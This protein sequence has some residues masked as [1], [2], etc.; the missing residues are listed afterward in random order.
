MEFKK[1]VLNAVPYELCEAD[2]T[3]AFIEILGEAMD[4]K[5]QLITK[6]YER[7]LYTV[8][9]KAAIKA[10]HALD[11]SEMIRL[12]EDVFK[13]KNINT[14]PH[15]RPIIVSFSKKEIEK[16]FKRIV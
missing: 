12:T 6:D 2:Y 16:Q 7:A 9:C 15:G 4:N 13:M 14:C 5:M 11:E 1:V 3:G 8:A 10:N